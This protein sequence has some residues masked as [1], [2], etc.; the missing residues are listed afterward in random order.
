MDQNTLKRDLEQLNLRYSDGRYQSEVF[1]EMLVAEVGL[2]SLKH[3][4]SEAV[5]NL[6]LDFFEKK[7]QELK[8]IFD[9]SNS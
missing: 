1:W 4:D 6:L 8:E 9:K 3:G 2:L 7:E 5:T